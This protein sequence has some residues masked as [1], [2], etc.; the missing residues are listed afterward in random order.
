VNVLRRCRFPSC[1]LPICS[2]VQT[3]TVR[4]DPR[5]SAGGPLPEIPALLFLPAWAF[6]V[7]I[8]PP[9]RFWSVRA[10]IDRLA[11]RSPALRDDGVCPVPGAGRSLDPSRRTGR[12]SPDGFE[13]LSA[14]VGLTFFFSRFPGAFTG[15]LTLMY[16][17]NVGLF[18]TLTP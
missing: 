3:R 8:A 9:F 10:D 17:G 13:V 6:H 15:H 1:F 18:F 2:A 11:V 7:S 5:P 14:V 16:S 12:H 4:F